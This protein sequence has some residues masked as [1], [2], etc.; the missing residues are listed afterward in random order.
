MNQKNLT[1]ILLIFLSNFILAAT[2]NNTTITSEGMN[3]TI[4][5]SDF[6]I[7]YDRLEVYDNAITFYNLSYTNPLSCNSQASSYSIYNYTTENSLVTLP[8]VECSNSEEDDSS[9]SLPV[10]GGSL[11]VVINIPESILKSKEGYTR[12]VIAGW[13]LNFYIESSSEKHSLKLNSVDKNKVSITISSEP[14]TFDV[15]INETKKVNLDKDNDYDLSIYLKSV[16]GIYAELVLKEINEEIFEETNL[17]EVKE[18]E[19]VVES[20]FNSL[21]LAIILFVV[22]VLVIVFFIAR[23]RK[24]KRRKLFGF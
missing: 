1:F 10:G 22:L 3:S 5:I 15:F 23:K 9:S 24:N 8:Y 20:N 21:Y 2:I 17:E 18:N 14:I 13:I 11:G 6:E 12:K 19:K 7:T 16:S 4:N